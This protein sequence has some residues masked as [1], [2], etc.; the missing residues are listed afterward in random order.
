MTESLAVT[1]ST[2]LTFFWCANVFYV[3]IVGI[4]Y[5]CLKFNIT[6]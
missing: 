5:F 2:I 4:L 6:L 3:G 1:T